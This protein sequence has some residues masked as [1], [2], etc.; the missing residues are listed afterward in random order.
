M[1]IGIILSPMEHIQSLKIYTTNLVRNLNNIDK[2][3]E[4]YLIHHSKVHL[5]I[6]E[7]NKE[8]ISDPPKIIFNNIWWKFHTLP[9]DLKSYDLD[10]VH[11]IQGISTFF[12]KNN[13]D[14]NRVMT[15][16]D[17]APLAFPKMYMKATLSDRL[18]GNKAI[19]NV[20]KIISVSKSTKNDLTRYFNTPKE[21]IE[22]I[23]L[24]VDE[25]FKV[26]DIK[27][28]KNFKEEYNLDFPFI[29]YLA[30]FRQRKNI[31]TLIKAYYLLRKEGLAHKLVLA[32]QKSD[33]YRKIL[34]LVKK[35]KLEK[36]VIF[37]GFIAADVLP[38]L[39]NAAD[40]F[41]FPSL[42]EGFGLPPLEAMACG[43]P[44]ITSKTSS[45]PEVVGDAGLMVNPKSKYELKDAMKT[46]LINSNLRTE[47]IKKGINRSKKFTWKRCAK[48]T[49]NVY[50]EVL[51]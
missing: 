10:L 1:N 13:S 34:N 29:L 50:K 39:Y 36:D 6:Y 30:A 42:Y 9:Q 22:P 21:K 40:L 4:Y 12:M 2:Q 27:Q 48:K 38:L 44:V 45:L 15:I 3:N 37:T 18:L 14:Y 43:C 46:L 26:I 24:G 19:K 28:I 20:D 23:Y 8:I 35:L 11:D 31:P 41:I 51:E 7:E 33:Q 49:L 5:D 47:L 17:L 32:G 16:H 25:K